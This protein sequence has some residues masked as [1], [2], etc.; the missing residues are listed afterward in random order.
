MLIK[1]IKENLILPI[2]IL[3]NISNPIL[4][5]ILL[6]FRII[7]IIIILILIIIILNNI[8]YNNDNIINKDNETSK[9]N[10]EAGHLNPKVR[11]ISGSYYFNY[12]NILDRYVQ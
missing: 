2:I 5:I 8:N 7:I 9:S 10:I 11:H 12:E 4:F 1:I 3:L 6:I